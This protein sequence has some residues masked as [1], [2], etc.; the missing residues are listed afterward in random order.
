MS[1]PLST[2]EVFAA[3]L[4]L[5]DPG[6]RSA[7]LDR[8]CAGNPELRK[9]VESLLGAAARAGAF[10]ESAPTITLKF[11]E[12]A[13]EVAGGPRKETAGSRLGRYKLLEQIGEGGFGVVWMAEQEEPVR[14]RVALKIIKLGMDTREVVARFEA[15]RQALAMMDHPNIASIFDGGATDTGR[16]YFVMEL[17]KGIPITTFCDERKLSTRQ[18]LELFMRVCQAVQHAHQKGVIHRDIKPSNVLVTVQDD[19]PV[20]KV[21][22][23]GVAKATQARLT[24]KTLF[25]RF[26]QW[27]GTPAYMSPEQAGL[28]SLD[29]D[30]RSD[31]YSLGVLLYELLTGRTPFD[32]Q[33]LLSSGYDAVMRTIREDDPPK[34]STRLSTLTEEELD[35]VAARRGAEPSHLN[36]VVRGDL[37]WVVMKALEKDR[38]RR[39]ET[40]NG[41]AMDLQRYLTNEPILARP[42]SNLYR[43]QKLARR[44]K[45]LFAAGG[46]AG[47]SLFI[48]LGIS[49]FLFFKEKAARE[50][51]VVAEQQASRARVGEAAQRQQAE[52]LSAKAQAQARQIGQQLYASHMNL[53]FQAWEKGDLPRVEELL[54]EHQSQ[55]GEDDLRGFEWFYL[56]RLCHSAQ[57]TLRGH[58]AQMRGV[59]FSPD[60]RLLATVGDDSVARVW[61]VTTGTERFALRGHAGSL[62]CVAFAP[63]GKTLAT[64]GI[65]Q[66]V[67]LWGADTG[68]ELAVLGGHQP[69]VSALAFGSNGNWLAAATGKCASGTNYGSPSEKFVDSGEL[70]AEIKVWRLDDRTVVHTLTGHTRSILSLAV[71]PDGKWLASGS[72]DASVKLWEVATGRS[73]TNLAG[74]GGPI[75]AV[76]F[77]PDGRALAVGGGDPYNER[78]VLE[79][80]DLLA[81]KEMVTLKGHEGPIFALAFAPSGKTLAAAGLD[82]VVRIWDVDTGDQQGSVKGHSASIWS[83]AY[84]RTGKRMATASWDHTVKVW[85]AEHSQAWERLVGAGGYSSCF[86][87]DGKYLI[88]SVPRLKVFEP[89]TSKPPMT[90]P[91]YQPLDISVAMSPDGRTLASA[92]TDGIVTLW[93]VGTWR[94]L[95]SLAGQLSKVWQL[96]FAPDGR[97]LASANEESVWLWDLER[98]VQRAVFYPRHGARVSAIS[99]TPDG[100][101]L[102]ASDHPGMTVF[103]DIV[104]GD[105]KWSLP[106]GFYALSPDG[107]YVVVDRQGLTLVELQTGQVKWHANPHRANLWGVWFSPDGRTLATASWDGTAKLWNV[108]SGQEMFT[109]K[110][111]GVV[112]SASFSPDG[113]WWAVGSGS[114]QKS[115]C[116]LFRAA[117][118]AQTRSRPSR[119]APQILLEPNS[120]TIIAGGTATLGVLAIGAQPL[121]YQWRRNGGILPGQTRASLILS[122]TSPDAAG[123]YSVVIT[124]ALGSLTSSNG[125]L[126]VVQVREAPIAEVN[127][128]DKLPSGGYYASTYSEHPATLATWITETPGAG[129]GG[130]TALVLRADRSGFRDTPQ[131]GWSGFGAAVVALASR[132]NGIDTTNLHAYRLDV[133][134]RVGGPLGPGSHGRVQWQFLTPRGPILSMNLFATYTTNYQT[135][136]FVLGDGCVDRNSGGSWAEFTTDFDQIDRVKCAVW[137]DHWLTEYSPNAD[138]ELFIDH[139]R[140][141][142]LLPV[143]SPPP[144][145][146]KSGNSAR[147]QENKTANNLGS[148]ISN[149]RKSGEK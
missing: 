117:T 94:R 133:T 81:Q 14:R 110:A 33:K 53:A 90:I 30:T 125:V 22:D 40:A 24:E 115:E 79:V 60:G 114:A 19:Q 108:A 109:Y 95:A 15:E 149:P 78:G 144:I 6:A 41:L 7:Y 93:E 17:V 139:V 132:A 76:A 46:L 137:A 54:D 36:R 65:D 64:G 9:E 35:V 87:L 62:T 124:N 143:S 121:H 142:R 70:P 48:G 134:A 97:T 102:I 98:R 44:N 104:S 73:R 130:A 106:G 52:L 29:V 141:V 26:S 91:D 11:L 42:P 128:Q 59:A 4:A 80:W 31:V 101:T 23:F 56:W 71:S 127:F 12:E 92:G 136:S 122:N 112:W 21:I 32:T 123:D 118:P 148:G 89:G 57:A 55:P 74:F 82:Q 84:D 105:T 63:D 69:G 96:A 37:D 138:N 116:A 67:R 34:P 8:V 88:E 126:S 49:T 51:A 72:A 83:L 58:N 3:A 120:P 86:S 107:R 27:I 66:T 145:D 140:F 2:D 13:Q 25:T 5:T 75:L 146:A 61:E 43:L 10:L 50:H 20:P 135:F 18:R 129:V 68:V 85:D 99:F 100:E 77:S 38:T 103:W 131:Q 119:H 16:P 113:E 39:Y 111:S 45:F 1:H 147:P 28:G 47:A